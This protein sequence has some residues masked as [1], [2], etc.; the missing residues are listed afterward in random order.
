M[1]EVIITPS[2]NKLKK[3]DAHINNRTISF[4][5]KRY[6]HYKTSDL[7]PKEL[8][9]YDEHHNKERRKNYIN[10]SSKIT[11]IYGNFTYKNKNSPNYWAYHLLW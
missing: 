1:I 7:I 4:G 3:F 10:R 8:H 5:D 9:I 6:Q 2:A 11:D